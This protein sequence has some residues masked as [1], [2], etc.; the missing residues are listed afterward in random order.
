MLSRGDIGAGPNPWLGTGAS[1][2]ASDRLM[3]ILRLCRR[4]RDPANLCDVAADAPR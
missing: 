3:R 2:V 1:N 4:D